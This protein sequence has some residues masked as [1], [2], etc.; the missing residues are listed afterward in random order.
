MALYVRR[1]GQLA[2]TLEEVDQ[3]LRPREAQ[4]E[5]CALARH[6][7]DFQR[8]LQQQPAAG[9]GRMAGTDL[10]QRLVAPDGT[11]YQHFDPAAAVLDAMQPGMQDARVVEHQQVAGAQQVG[12][13]GEAPVLPA[14]AVHDQQPAG[15]ALGQRELGDQLRRQVVIEIGEGQR[16]SV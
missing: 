16:H 12:Q 11:L 9:P 14:V 1:Q 13:I 4:Q 6:H 3:I 10:R 7:A 2:V 5:E 8:A 15:G